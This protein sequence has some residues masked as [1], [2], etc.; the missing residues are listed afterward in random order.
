LVAVAAAGI[1][2]GPA[3]AA[4][5]CTG[6]IQGTAASERLTVVASSSNRV[7]G[8]EGDDDITG[9][10]GRDC[11]DGG[12]GRDL[13]SGRSGSDVLIGGPGS[14]RLAGGSGGDRIT[15]APRAYA[16]GLGSGSN[17]VAGGPGADVVDV[18]NARRDLVQCG[19]G[20]DRVSADRNDRLRGCER[21]RLLASPV[22]SAAPYRGKRTTTFLIR[23][24]TIEEVSTTGEFFTIEVN[25]PPGCGAI[26]TSSL[27]VRYRRDA[28][29]RYRVKPFSGDGESAKR[30]CRGTYRGTVRFEQ[31]LAGGCGPAAIPGAA[32]C[33]MGIRVGGFSFR[34]R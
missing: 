26:E 34:V 31:V 16:F 15:D 27:G 19:P 28:V 2:A 4:S 24:R 22:P 14:D 8:M 20:R 5:G 9:S 33:T 12:P 1:L 7:L 25:G 21:K 6:L 13:L 10:A 29:V 30:W 11:L 17:R 3:H 23:F 32:G 18:A